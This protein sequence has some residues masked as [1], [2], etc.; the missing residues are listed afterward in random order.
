MASTPVKFARQYSTSLTAKLVSAGGS[1]T[2]NASGYACTNSNG[3]QSFTVAEALVGAFYV[4]AYDS[5]SEIAY[6]GFVIL[7][8]TTDA[9]FCVDDLPTAV[10]NEKLRKFFSNRAPIS[11][12]A[13]GFQR[14]QTYNDDGSESDQYDWNPS[15][16]TIEPV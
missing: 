13:S 9:H 6:N 1:G 5:L 7:A 12:A 15:N 16:G 8:D 11:G 10:A 2:P 4:Y 3:L 14:F